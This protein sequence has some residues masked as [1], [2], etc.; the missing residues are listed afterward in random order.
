MDSTFWRGPEAGARA[1]HDSAFRR[2]IPEINRSRAA[3]QV[4][5]MR[6][7]RN[8]S[9]LEALQFDAGAFVAHVPRVQSCFRFDQDYVD[10]FLRDGHVLD[11]LGDDDEFTRQ[12]GD[13]AIAEAHAQPAFYDQKHFILVVV[14]MPDEFAAELYDLH[15]GIVQLADDCGAPVF[16]YARQF[17]IQVYRF[18]RQSPFC[19]GSGPPPRKAR[20][21]LITFVLPAPRPSRARALS[22]PRAWSRNKCA[23]CFRCRKRAASASRCHPNT[24]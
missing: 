18:H 19:I 9:A 10:F 23:A 4:A 12:H 11:A 6:R 16:D 20:S 7:M 14:M 3:R 2:H 21:V 8:C 5:L 15:V 17:F 24:L 13:I 1:M 22:F